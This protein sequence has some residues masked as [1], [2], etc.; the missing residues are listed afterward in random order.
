MYYTSHVLENKTIQ[1]LLSTSGSFPGS[2]I[3]AGDS[4]TQRNLIDKA[5]YA[6]EWYRVVNVCGRDREARAFV[7]HWSEAWQSLEWGVTRRTWQPL[8]WGVTATGM[9]RENYWSDVFVDVRATGVRRDL[10]GHRT[11]DDWP[12][13]TM[14]TRRRGSSVHWH[15]TSKAKDSHR[16]N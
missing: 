12:H 13:P 5:S 3:V 16:A 2:G 1:F 15:D 10:Q 14:T 11:N 6:L 9:I 8:E 7:R 4:N